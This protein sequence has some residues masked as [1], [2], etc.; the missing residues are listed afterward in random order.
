MND[1]LKQTLGLAGF[2]AVSLVPACAELRLEFDPEELAVRADIA[3]QPLQVWLRN[4]G[5]ET[6][7]ILGGTLHVQIVGDDPSGGAPRLSGIDFHQAWG[8]LFRSDN[9]TLTRIEHGPSLWSAVVITQPESM[10]VE[11]WIPP[12]GILPLVTVK[13]DTTGITPRPGGWRLR[14][15]QTPEG[16]SILDRIDPEDRSVI[17]P[18][19]MRVEE[20][21]LGI[22]S[23]SPT[24]AMTVKTQQ[25]GALEIEFPIPTSGSVT[26]QS[27]RDLAE[28]VWLNVDQM[29]SS[30]GSRLR[31]TLSPETADERVFF[32]IV[33]SELKLP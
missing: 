17:L 13:I 8:S 2:L 6:V 25:G 1:R 12:F 5:S 15:A 28:G 14:M 30:S 19:R 10:P 4:T 7:P 11:V 3:D 9:A 27:C 18:I 26:L 16:D 33:T 23:A 29:P 32:R 21:L 22:R 20:A 31:W 24:E